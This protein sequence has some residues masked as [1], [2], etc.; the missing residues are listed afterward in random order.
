MSRFYSLSLKALHLCFTLFSVI[1]CPHF[2]LESLYS[3]LHFIHVVFLFLHM[4]VPLHVYSQDSSFSFYRD[5]WA[6]VGFCIFLYCSLLSNVSPQ[7]NIPCVC[8][9]T[10]SHI[11][12]LLQ[13][14]EQKCSAGLFSAP[15]PLLTPGRAGIIHCFW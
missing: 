3:S 8:I 4:P 5:S 12:Y 9:K 13:C 1:K 6:L 11:P 10:R 15:P 14:S 7:W 2:P